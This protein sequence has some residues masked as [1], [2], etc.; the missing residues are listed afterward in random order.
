MGLGLYTRPQPILTAALPTVIRLAASDA[1]AHSVVTGTA[2]TVLKTFSFTAANLPVIATNSI[3]A[4]HTLWT[5][6]GSVNSKT[7]RVRIGAAAAGTGGTGAMQ[8]ITTTAGNITFNRTV[9]IYCRGASSQI[10]PN[11]SATAEGFTNS[12]VATAA[13]DLTANWEICITGQTASSGETIQLE[14]SAV[15]IQIP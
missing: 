12:A 15:E 5:I 4:I 8:A 6:T 2:E 9:Y 10:I 3:I 7:L 1:S 11:L 14:A 13:I